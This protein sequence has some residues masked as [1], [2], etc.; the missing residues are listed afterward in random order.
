MARLSLISEDADDIIDIDDEDELVVPMDTPLT[1]DIFEPESVDIPVIDMTGTELH[2]PY[3][4]RVKVAAEAMRLG[5][6]IRTVVVR[7]SCE[8]RDRINPNNWGIVTQV[9]T[10][11]LGGRF[12]PIE[13]KW[14][15]RKHLYTYH[16]PKE[17]VL[18]MYPPDDLDLQSIMEDASNV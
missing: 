5:F 10:Y 12:A 13:V 1:A 14:L 11:E 17:L 7:A 18:C 16:Y 2:L 3:E 6:D 9:V 4:E 8:G 15:D